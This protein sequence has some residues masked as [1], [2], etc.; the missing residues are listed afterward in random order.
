MIRLRFRAPGR[1]LPAQVL[2][3]RALPDVPTS[4]IEHWI[5]GGAL[6]RA[7]VGKGGWSPG[8]PLRGGGDPIPPGTALWM[9]VDW[10]AAEPNPPDTGLQVL[11]PALAWPEAEISSRGGRLR[12]RVVEERGRLCRAEVDLD[13][14]GLRPFLEWA[15]TA[16]APVLGDVRRGGILVEGGLRVAPVGAVLPWPAEPVFPPSAERRG[17]RD[18]PLEISAEAATALRRGHPWLLADAGTGDAGRWPAGSLVVL[19]AP[20]REPIGQARIEDDAPLL[21]RV[22]SRGRTRAGR[23]DTVE[24]RIRR[25]VARRSGLLSAAGSPGGTD[26]FR[27]VHGE[28]DGLPGLSVDRLGPLLRVVVS[29]RAALGIR[30]RVIDG[31]RAELARWLDPDAPVVEV[32]HLRRAPPGRLLCVRQV[33]GPA[34][35]PALRSLSVREGALRFRIDPGLAEPTQPRPGVGLFLDQRDNRARIARRVVPGGRYLNLFA[36]TGAFSAVLLAAGAGEVTSVDLSAA[37]LAWL[38]ENLK[39]NG[40]PLERHRCLRRDARRSLEELAPALR[41]QGIVVDPPTAAAAGQR[42]WSVRRGM[43]R[44]LGSALARLAP[45]G[46][47]LAARNDRAGRGRLP[48]LLEAVAADA[49][50]PVESL[51]EAPPAQ[52]FPRLLH[53]PEGDPFEAALL[54]RA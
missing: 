38:E 44:L 6:R 11:L 48:A 18:A 27:I 10:R 22:W 4:R 41:F 24:S 17:G 5:R 46:W 49:G 2:L 35:H 43:G 28:A 9:E 30:E 20:G 25:A 3:A 7:R 29:G 31:L 52:D 34:E 12:L 54:V 15:A 42:F 32:M 21:A 16:L 26:A 36:H 51:E 40:L 14:V 33:R 1:A 37:Y 50:V 23:E 47:L 13:G 39:A 53:F 8:A 19:E 45:G